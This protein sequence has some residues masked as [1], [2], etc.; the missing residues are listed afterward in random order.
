[1]DGYSNIEIGY[2]RLRPVCSGVQVSNVQLAQSP[3]ESY[4]GGQLNVTIPLAFTINLLLPFPPASLSSPRYPACLSRMYLC[5]GA[6]G[7]A[8]ALAF[9]TRI[10][11][12]GYSG[13][14]ALAL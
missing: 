2:Q 13:E 11:L 9:R 14:T 5:G 7:A 12:N 6:V 10:C 4:T 1:M 3:R 8:R